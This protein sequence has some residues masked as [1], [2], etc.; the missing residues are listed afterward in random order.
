MVE[1]QV[2]IETCIFKLRNASSHFLLLQVPAAAVDSK[3]CAEKRSSSKVSIYIFLSK[4]FFF[5]Q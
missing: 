3:L 1:T 5:F 2:Y 4:T